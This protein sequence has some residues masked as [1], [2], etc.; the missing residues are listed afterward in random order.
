YPSKF[1]IYNK[2]GVT[3]PLHFSSLAKFET[4]T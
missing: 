2:L 4:K 1:G 3:D